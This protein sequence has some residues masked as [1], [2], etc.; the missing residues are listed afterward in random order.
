MPLQWLGPL[1]RQEFDPWPENM[2]MPWVQP[3]EKNTGSVVFGAYCSQRVNFNRHQSCSRIMLTHQKFQHHQNL[4]TT[5]NL[6]GWGL[7][8]CLLSLRFEK[9]PG[10][11]AEGDCKNQR[12]QVSHFPDERI[13]A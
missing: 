1:L 4:D 11:K 2:H 9:L 5:L 6:Q 12:V 7:S 13:E 10:R 3:K 8:V